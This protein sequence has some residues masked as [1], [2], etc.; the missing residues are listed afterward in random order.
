MNNAVKLTPE[1]LACIENL[2]LLAHSIVDGI[3][4]GIHG[5]RKF[6]QSDN[7]VDIR[8][9]EMGDPLRLIDWKAYARTDKLHIRKFHDDSNMHVFILLDASASMG[10][11]SGESSKF[12]Y[13]ALLAACM[14]LVALKQRDAVGF[15]AFSGQRLELLERESGKEQFFRIAETLK[16]MK[17]EGRNPPPD[18]AGRLSDYLKRK[19]L[20]I[21]I[22]DLVENNG[23]IMRSASELKGMG[24]DLLI[25]HTL[26]PQELS[27]SYEGRVKL[28]DPETN[29]KI[30]MDAKDLRDSYHQAM[31]EFLS[32]TEKEATDMGARYFLLNTGKPMDDAVRHVLAGGKK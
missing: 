30:T 2:D 26:D 8:Q 19:N 9:Y 10:F 13:G 15:A 17:P 14:T 7:F 18:L 21:L 31:R 24:H 29:G 27:F 20:V 23:G 25:L 3:Y 28:V 5:S 16:A 4:T 32:K 22:S 1:N 11:A 12:A 6:G